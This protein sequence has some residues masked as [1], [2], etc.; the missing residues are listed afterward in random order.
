LS[1]NPK[2]KMMLDQ[3]NSIPKLD[4]KTI[5]PKEYRA[6][7]EQMRQAPTTVER[8]GAVEDKKLPLKDRD[9][10]VRVYKPEGNG[11]FPALVY[12]H[13]GGW[14][15]G[16]IDSHDGVCRAIVNMAQCTVISV[17]YRLAPEHKFPAGVHDA[18]DAL[19]YISDHAEEFDIDANRIAVGGDSAGGNLAAVTSIIA[20][21][22]G[23]PSI[24]HQFL[25][26]PST[27]RDYELPSMKENSEGYFLTQE[28]M[29]WFGEHYVNKQEDWKHPYASPV[30]AEDLSNLPPA[31][32]LT[33]QYDPLRD[34]GALYAE[35]LRENEVPVFYKNYHDLIH[36]FANFIEFV[37]EAR[38]ALKEGAE[39]LKEAF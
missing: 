18:Y 16:N 9:I 12:Y 32:I 27:G 14:V 11:K 39:S 28:L 30:L 23:G 36:G 22:K 21:E 7:Q 6:L 33:A 37:P 38:E 8:V 34:S 35:K 17:D 20:K 19:V 29:E 31:T 24:I 13:G 10:R 15:L 4:L 3:M 26:Y 2:I 1:L 5:T 25:L